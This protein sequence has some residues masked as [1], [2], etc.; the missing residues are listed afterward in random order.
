MARVWGKTV[1]LPYPQGLYP[2]EVLPNLP[3]CI[4]WFVLRD[5]QTEKVLIEKQECTSGSL[6]CLLVMAVPLST[7]KC[8]TDPLRPHSALGKPA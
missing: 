1:H 7:R 5:L 3:M 6:S 2:L 4:K 8:D